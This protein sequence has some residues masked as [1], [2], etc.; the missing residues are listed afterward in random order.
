M[1]VWG[2]FRADII[3]EGCVILELK[4]CSFLNAAHSVQL[5]NYL[6]ATGIDDGLMINFGSA[7]LGFIHKTRI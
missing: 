4:V 2:D 1:N 3:V 5:V 7:N 6:T